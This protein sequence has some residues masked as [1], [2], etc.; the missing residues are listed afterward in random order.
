V[1]F[2][3]VDHTDILKIEDL[4]GK[5]FMAVSPLGFGGWR[6]G[7]KILKAHG[8]DPETDFASL[9]FAGKQPRV[10]EAIRDKKAHA[11][12]VRTDMLERLADKGKLNLR[13]VRILNQQSTPGF[14]FFHSTPL[15]PEWP[16]VAMPHTSAELTEQVKQALLKLTRTDPAA[17]AGKYMGWTP[18]LDYQPVKA[19]LRDLGVAPYAEQKPGLQIFYLLFGLTA[20]LVVFYAFKR[21]S[22]KRV[23]S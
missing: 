16:F 21:Y 15:Y 12:M 20:L 2:T 6:V 4:K 10:V 17:Q 18:A 11:G 7:S 22:V 5:D 1:I 9:N 14:P 13:N 19:L 23:G 8:I 3:H